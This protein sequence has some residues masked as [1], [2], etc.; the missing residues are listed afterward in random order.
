MLLREVVDETF[1][2]LAVMAHRIIRYEHIWGL[3]VDAHDSFETAYI[4]SSLAQEHARA[5]ESVIERRYRRT[6]PG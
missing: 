2:Q 4:S 3:P 1:I 5:H 6:T